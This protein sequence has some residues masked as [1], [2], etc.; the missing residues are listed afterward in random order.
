MLLV[1]FAFYSFVTLIFVLQSEQSGEEEVIS[2]DERSKFSKTLLGPRFVGVWSSNST[3]GLLS[4]FQGRA[5]ASF[6]R[7]ESYEFDE[8]FELRLD[9][10][11]Y[12]ILQVLDPEFR[13]DRFL[14]I[15]QP[16][17]TNANSTAFTFEK[18]DKQSKGE[19]ES[20][21]S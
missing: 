13:D 6:A 19:K 12:L 5:K 16:L 21:T 1:G 2:Y 8:T 3:G 4:H 20:N 7:I 15:V 14:R 18:A 11:L 10:A 9:S 17:A